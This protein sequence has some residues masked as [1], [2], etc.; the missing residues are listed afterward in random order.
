MIGNRWR[1]VI[2]IA[3]V[4]KL[5]DTPYSTIPFRGHLSCDAPC[6]PL[7]L[8][9]IVQIWGGGYSTIP[10]AIGIAIPY[11]SI[12]GVERLGHE[13]GHEAFFREGGGVIYFEA[14]QT[15]NLIP[16]PLYTHPTPR[17][18]FLGVGGGPAQKHPNSAAAHPKNAEKNCIARTAM[19][20]RTKSQRSEHP[21]F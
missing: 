14:P 1:F 15:S 9:A 13:A 16:P 20:M 8:A 6:H 18:V 17:R 7:P 12:A 21:Y 19:P 3:W 4:T 11:S 5:S 10:G 2:A